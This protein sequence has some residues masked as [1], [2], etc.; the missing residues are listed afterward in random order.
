LEILE[1]LERVVENLVI[2]SSQ[3]TLS[4]IVIH[5]PTIYYQ[6][7]DGNVVI[8]IAC[9]IIP[10]TNKSIF[11]IKLNQVVDYLQG[12]RKLANIKVY[13]K[14]ETLEGI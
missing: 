6:N 2:F 4:G 7:G 12:N 8:L 9:I 13:W 3:F 11:Q 5:K 14:W 1:I 10:T